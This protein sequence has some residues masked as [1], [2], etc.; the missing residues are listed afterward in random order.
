MISTIN[1][2][3]DLFVQKRI[4]GW[5]DWEKA[6]GLM[7]LVFEKRPTFVVEIGIYGGKSFIPMAAAVKY[8]KFG[9]IYG[10][11]PWNAAA[12]I[13][14]ECEANRK[15]WGDECNYENVYAK[16]MQLVKSLELPCMIVRK[17]SDDVA[18]PVRIDLLHIDGNHTGQ[19]IKDTE[20][21][22]PSVPIGGHVV[23]DDLDWS[24]GAVRV[25]EKYLI[26]HGFA[27]MYLLGTG[28]VYRRVK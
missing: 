3:H 4:D 27:M 12:S 20:K 13:E 1:M 2:V 16:F 9:T 5:C 11:D 28:A 6:Y 24:G 18:R 25:S 21:F 15:F 26:G 17:R 22:V 23:L 8:N 10:I 14:G 7:R 19:A